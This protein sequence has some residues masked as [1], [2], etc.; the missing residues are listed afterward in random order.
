LL[1]GEFAGLD[2][3]NATRNFDFFDLKGDLQ[4]L[5]AVF[6]IEDCQFLSDVHPALHP[7][8]AARITYLQETV[9]WIGT[10]HPRLLDELDIDSEVVLFELQLAPLTQRKITKYQPISKYPQI[11]RDLSFLVDERISAGEIEQTIRQTVQQGWLKSFDLFDLY[12]GK[13]IPEGKKSLGISLT[14]QDNGRTLIDDEINPLISA[15]IN[16]LEEKFAIILRD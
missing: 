7:G 13:N 1:T 12:T 15:I 3:S 16:K 9:G 14:L 11:R 5:M 6:Q 10:L 4:A 8:Q 2:W